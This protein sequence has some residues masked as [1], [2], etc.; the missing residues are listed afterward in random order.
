MK[1]LTVK[2]LKKR[3]ASGYEARQELDNRKAERLN[4][5]HAHLVGTCQKYL[6]SYGS[7]D[8]WWL[9]RRILSVNG[10][11][12]QAFRFQLTTDKRIEIETDKHDSISDS[13]V[14]ITESEY[15]QACEALVDA[16]YSAAKTGAPQ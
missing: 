9:Y 11:W 6:N 14:P 7:G 3:M 4:K 15:T 2:Q 8:S 5:Q 16:M 12:C 1:K 10:Q 13:W